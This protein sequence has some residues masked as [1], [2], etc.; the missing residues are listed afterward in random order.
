MF[1]R[2][3]FSY[4]KPK[5]SPGVERRGDS[6][7]ASVREG[8]LSSPCPLLPQ[9]LLS[10]TS[11]TSTRRDSAWGSRPGANQA[12]LAISHRLFLRLVAG[13]SNRRVPLPLW[14]ARWKGWLVLLVAAPTA[15]HHVPSRCPSGT[16]ALIDFEAC[17]EKA[18][19]PMS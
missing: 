12:S 18:E 16:C 14:K 17:Q 10:L 15:G 5:P 7:S 19:V 11:T 2:L 6:C 8:G 1:L 9:A 13:T 4:A 3:F